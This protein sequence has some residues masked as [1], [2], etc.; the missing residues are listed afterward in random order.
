MTKTI[1]S[2]AQRVLKSALLALALLTTG[3]LS[4]PAQALTPVE[5]Q[6]A[7][8]A[9]QTVLNS[10]VATAAEQAQLWDA[11]A[12]YQGTGGSITET[13][14]T[15]TAVQEAELGISSSSNLVT[16]V[17]IGLYGVILAEVVYLGYQS[18]LYWGY[19]AEVEEGLDDYLEIAEEMEQDLIEAEEE[20][21]DGLYEEN[22]YWDNFCDLY[23]CP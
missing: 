4:T 5:T 18:Y 13:E 20:Y 22:G 7:I 15:L 1:P 2:P 10:G 9:I 19:T 12:Y 3:G 11:L 14:I 17:R 21:Y 8:T 16:V 6:A 23:W